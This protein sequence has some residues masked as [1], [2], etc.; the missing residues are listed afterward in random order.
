MWDKLTA[1]EKQVAELLLQGCD[2]DEIAKITEMGIRTVKAHFGRM[3]LR[4]Q[5]SGGVK[6]VKLATLLYRSQ[7]CQKEPIGLLPENKGTP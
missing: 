5:I 7:I 3:F 4:F 1:R 2:N 6:R